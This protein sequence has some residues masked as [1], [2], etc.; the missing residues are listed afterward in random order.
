MYRPP[1]FAPTSMEDDKVSKL[2]RNALRKEKDTL[3]QARQSAYVRDLMD[4]L[5]GKPEEVSYGLVLI[6]LLIS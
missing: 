3:R 5:Q 2:E 6:L 4:D 1:K